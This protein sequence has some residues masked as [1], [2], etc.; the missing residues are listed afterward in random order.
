MGDKNLVWKVVGVIVENKN[1]GQEKTVGAGVVMGQTK[2]VRFYFL[3]LPICRTFV[4]PL[5]LPPP[6][7]FSLYFF[8][9]LFF[10]I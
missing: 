1:Y 2:L 10:F 4:L 8:L 7:P 3:D 5:P 9:F 6:F